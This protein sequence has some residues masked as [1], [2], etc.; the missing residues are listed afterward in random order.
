MCS[1]RLVERVRVVAT[2][3]LRVG[4]VQR[5]LGVVARVAG[6]Q[7]DQLRHAALDLRVPARRGGAVTPCT[8]GCRRT[9]DCSVGVS[10]QRGPN[11]HP[12]GAWFFI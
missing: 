3:G 9:G 7:R 12:R 11:I 2:E 8:L 6:H 1:A 4:G 10:A 5:E